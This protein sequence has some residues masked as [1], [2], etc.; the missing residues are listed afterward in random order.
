MAVFHKNRNMV[1]ALEP[2]PQDRWVK[3]VIGTRCLTVQHI[4]QYQQAVDWAV[5]MAD[6]FDPPLHIVPFDVN[7]L[8]KL[9]RN[10]LERGLALLTPDEQHRLRQDVVNTCV[11][12]MRDCD[13]PSVRNDAYDV[14]Q[15]MRVV[16]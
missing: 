8:V 3:T 2:E 6:Q 14:L 16:Q 11:E 10:R 15:K 1:A 7:D 4:G 12:V 9:N 5:R 13:D